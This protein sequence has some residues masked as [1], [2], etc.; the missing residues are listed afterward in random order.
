VSARAIRLWIL[1]AI[2]ACVAFPAHAAVRVEQD[3]VIF[4]IK[5]PGAS[6]VFVMGDFNRWNP[7]LEK[8]EANGDVFE[9]R[10]FLVA[11]EYRYKFVVDGEERVDPDNPGPVERGSPLKLVERSGGLMLETEVADAAGDVPVAHGWAR[12]IG[13]LVGE[14]GES[15]VTQRVDAEVFGRYER[16]SGRARVAT[17]DSSWTWDPLGLDAYFDR[18]RVT[19]NLGR[20]TVTGFEN[21]STWASRDPLQLVGNAGVFDYDAGFQ[22]HGASAEARGKHAAF[23]VTWA[24]A[25]GR[26]TAVPPPLDASAADDFAGGGAAD[27]TLFAYLPTTNDADVLA[28]EA[29]LTSGNLTLGYTQRDEMGMNPGMVAEITRGTADFATRLTHTREEREVATTWLRRK[30]LFGLDVAGAYGWGNLREDAVSTASTRQLPPFDLGAGF[31]SLDSDATL[32]LLE[33]RRGRVDL[34]RPGAVRVSLAWD[35]VWF[36]FSGVEGESDADVQRYRA[37][38][39]M[40]RKT[41]SWSGEVVYTDAAYGT[42]PDALYIDTPVRNPWLS[43]FDDVDVPSM[44][45]VGLAEHTVLSAGAGWR[46][47][48]T[49]AGADMVVQGDGAFERIVHT[50]VHLFAEQR[51]RERWVARADARGAWYPDAPAGRDDAYLSGYLEAGYA[52]NGIQLNL[53]F[54]FD[55]VVFDPVIGDYAEIGYTSFLRRAVQGGIRRSDASGILDRLLQEEARLRDAAAIKLECVIEFE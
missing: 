23:A 53:G 2:A 31:A 13:R 11:G 19:A 3:E 45:G 15:D 27:T 12:Y 43:L 47:E 18:G 1:A 52:H 14:D 17:H 8:L 49:R 54:G 41:W 48:A 34:A 26:D 24:D 39:E 21:D 9:V 55:P 50:Q 22:R 5:A 37:R 38:A 51:V 35:G 32:P 25:T 29:S 33:T 44:V 28:V 7:T 16:L 46:R 4:S 42:S 36:D 10:L 30:Q 6:E 20:L 40:E